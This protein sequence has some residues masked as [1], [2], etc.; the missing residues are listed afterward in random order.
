MDDAVLGQSKRV[1]ALTP[2]QREVLRLVAEGRTNAEI[3]DR[4]GVTPGT[5]GTQVGRILDR[6]GLECRA[7]IAPWVAVAIAGSRL[8]HHRVG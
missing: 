4:L 7:E 5:V 1:P 6:L 3:A 8:P 2:L